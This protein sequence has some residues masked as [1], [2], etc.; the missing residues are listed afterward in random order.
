MT[1]TAVEPPSALALDSLPPLP[2]SLWPV[3]PPRRNALKHQSHSL[4]IIGIL[5]PIVGTATPILTPGGPADTHTCGRHHTD[6]NR[7][8]GCGNPG[9]CLQSDD[10][11][12]AALGTFGALGTSR[13]V[14]TILRCGVLRTRVAVT[15]TLG[16]RTACTRRGRTASTRRRP[17]HSTGVSGAPG[18]RHTGVL[19]RAVDRRRGILMRGSRRRIRRRLRAALAVGARLG[20]VARLGVGRRLG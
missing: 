14:A 2:R 15:S 20:V 13:T 5:I 18:L 10:L 9:A 7:P 8:P 12:I 3:L 1:P 19:P 17:R 4:L 16:R 6:A 11:L